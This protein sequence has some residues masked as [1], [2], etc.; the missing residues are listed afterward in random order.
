MFV[1]TCIFALFLKVA[2]CVLHGCPS[3]H[4]TP[5]THFIPHESDC[6]KYYVCEWGMAKERQCPDLMYWS[7]VVNTCVYTCP[8]GN[9]L[10]VASLPST[11]V[12]SKP[13]E[14]IVTSKP[15]VQLTTSRVIST[16]LR[17]IWDAEDYF[18]TE[19]TVSD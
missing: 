12:T 14:P 15:F 10:N 2:C 13:L 4:N 5:G 16:S 3:Q 6:R 1:K 8:R 18:N 17:D 9:S 11:S 7:P 19:S